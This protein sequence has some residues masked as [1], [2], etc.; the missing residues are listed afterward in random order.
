M[1]GVVVYGLPG[2]VQCKATE[3]QLGKQGIEYEYIDLSKSPED[4]DF[5]RDM[6]VTVAPYVVVEQDGKP[7]EHWTG[8]QPERINAIG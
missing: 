4:M 6:G 3:R 1:T 5:V 8:F 2:C 7:V